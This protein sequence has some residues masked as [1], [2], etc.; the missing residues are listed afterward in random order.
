[1]LKPEGRLALTTNLNGHWREFYSVFKDTAEQLQKP[2]LARQLGEQEAQRGNKDSITKYFTAA[3]LNI[4]K[5]EEESFDMG[6]TDGNAFLNHYFVKLGWLDSWRKLIPENE[7][8]EVF[9]QLEK[10]L[11]VLAEKDGCLKLSVPM[12]YMEAQKE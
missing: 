9:A 7:Q 1:V 4:S 3:G 11:N 2:R 5:Q 10:N 6:F 12:L 8:Q